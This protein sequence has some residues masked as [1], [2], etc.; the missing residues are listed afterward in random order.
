MWQVISIINNVRADPLVLK[1]VCY[2]VLLLF[3][4]EAIYQD[5]S[6]F[7]KLYGELKE[8]KSLVNLLGKNGNERFEQMV[9]A[10]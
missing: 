7:Y 3:K 4:Q 10:A 1:S 6:L 2:F 5:L 9:K 8:M